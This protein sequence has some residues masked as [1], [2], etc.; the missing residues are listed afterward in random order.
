M[1]ESRPSKPKAY[2][3]LGQYR[4]PQS[5]RIAPIN[6]EDPYATSA[7]AEATAVA[8][9]RGAVTDDGP[10]EWQAK[11]RRMAAEGSKMRS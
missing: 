4:I 7:H 3:L 5:D 6:I 10:V 11:Q 2:S 9:P 8:P 1:A